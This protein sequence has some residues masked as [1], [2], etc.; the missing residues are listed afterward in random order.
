MDSGAQLRE[1]GEALPEVV[2][3]FDEQ[4]RAPDASSNQ[5][6]GHRAGLDDARVAG[7][8]L[9][10]RYRRRR[11]AGVLAVEDYG[12]FQRLSMQD[13][14]SAR[15]RQ[16]GPAGKARWGDMNRDKMLPDRT[17]SPGRR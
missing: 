4:P 17:D 7:H 12:G 11:R 2:S 10:P 15:T 13:I 1:H 8:R 3:A 14:F 5:I 6:L 16:E 9:H